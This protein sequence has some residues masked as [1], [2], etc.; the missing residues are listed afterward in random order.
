MSQSPRDMHAEGDM[1]FENPTY[2]PEEEEAVKKK[3]IKI[4]LFV[5]QIP[6]NWYYF[7]RL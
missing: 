4:K 1:D 2:N 7:A 6:K 5:G 3:H